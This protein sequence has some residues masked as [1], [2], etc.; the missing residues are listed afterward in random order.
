MKVVGF[1]KTY[2]E[3]EF[4]RTCKLI[5]ENSLLAKED[6]DLN[7]VFFIFDIKEIS[8]KFCSLFM[9]IKIYECQSHISYFE[10]QQLFCI[11]TY[12]ILR[13]VVFQNYWSGK[14][15]QLQ[16]LPSKSSTEVLGKPHCDSTMRSCPKNEL[17]FFLLHFYGVT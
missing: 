9:F 7:C 17:Q 15:G 3:T 14:R 8:L 4:L 11:D 1:L 5:S 2:F 6:N 10:T 13:K 16:R 12:C